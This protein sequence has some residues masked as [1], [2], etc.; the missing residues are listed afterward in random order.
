MYYAQI[1]N[2]AV[3][4]WKTQNRYT[5]FNQHIVYKDD[6]GMIYPSDMKVNF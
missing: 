4:C 2:N 5:I 3:A 6:V 1:Q